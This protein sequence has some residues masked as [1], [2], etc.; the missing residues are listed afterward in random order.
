VAGSVVDVAVHRARQVA[1]QRDLE[2]NFKVS[3]NGYCSERRAQFVGHFFDGVVLSFD[4]T[5]ELHDRNRPATR[6]RGSFD[7]VCRTA[8]LL[9]RSPTELCF[10]MCVTMDALDRMVAVTKWFCRRFR[11]AIIN[12]EPLKPNALS[13][14]KGLEVPD[15]YRFAK[16]YLEAAAAAQAC[17]VQTV[18]NAADRDRMRLSFCPLGKDAV[19]VDPS[20]ELSACYLM[21][22]DWEARGMDLTLGAIEPGGEV[23]LDMGRVKAMRTLVTAKERC[24]NCFCRWS[25]A[26][27]CHVGET[28]PGSSLTYTAFCIQTRLITACELLQDLGYGELGKEL[29]G[30]P[31]ARETLALQPDDRLGEETAQDALGTV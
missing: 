13:R 28:Y 7:T 9:G 29:L 27:A 3:T 4:G 31:L 19:I 15:P 23:R 21:K 30:S 2:T 17:G 20:G 6:T 10:R 11:P 25:C 5:R 26:G 24:R 12:F 22:R 1:V 8:D 18:Y 16:A 14:Q